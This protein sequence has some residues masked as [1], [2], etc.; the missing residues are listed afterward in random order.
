MSFRSDFVAGAK[1]MAPLLPPGATVGLVTGIA[2]AAAGLTSIQTISMAV[3]VHSPTVMLTAF[4]LLE[5]GAPM[6]ILIVAPLIVGAR[7][8]LLSFSIAPYF[9][10]LTTGW[11]WVLAYFL[12]TPTYAIS[13]EQYE[14]EPATHRRGYYLGAA[15]P[16]WMTFQSAL[17]LGV[18]FG[19]RVPAGWHLGFVIPL[20]F[21]ALL[22]R[23]VPDRPAKGAALVA[24]VVAVLASTLP[25]NVGIIVAAIAG[26]AAGV[27][28][29]RRGSR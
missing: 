22:V 14:S 12:W 6:I 19:A 15:V 23:L 24:G 27:I 8:A 21:I 13:I 3:I 9:E 26:T 2:A 28:G 16:L 25:L 10:R 29:N 4:S 11:K 5:S 18:V 7:F 17:V 20:A 1:S